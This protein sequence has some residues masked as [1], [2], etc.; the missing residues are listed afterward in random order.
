VKPRKTVFPSGA[1]S[2]VVSDR[3]SI[4][5]EATSGSLYSFKYSDL[6]YHGPAHAGPRALRRPSHEIC[7]AVHLDA[8][9]IIF[10]I[11]GAR[12]L[13]IASVIATVA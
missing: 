12:Q 5:I 10:V 8:T 6:R 11:H 7:T 1:T 9:V 4:S 13:G 3:D 2:Q